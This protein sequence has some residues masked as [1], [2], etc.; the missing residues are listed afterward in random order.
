MLFLFFQFFV[1]A[2]KSGSLFSFVAFPCNRGACIMGLVTHNTERRGEGGYWMGGH[3]FRISR[4]F[5]SY[6]ESQNPRGTSRRGPAAVDQRGNR[7][8]R[9]S[10]NVQ[11]KKRLCLRKGGMRLRR[12]SR[13]KP[14]LDGARKGGS[15]DLSCFAKKWR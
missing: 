7:G 5:P 8:V 13:I 14:A 15:A 6:T 3:P 2:R 10:G 12:W 1:A 11:R 4:I 9:A